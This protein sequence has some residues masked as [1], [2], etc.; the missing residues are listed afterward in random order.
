MIKWFCD[1]C[2][3]EIT[4]TPTS[5]KAYHCLKSRDDAD[6]GWGATD[7]IVAVMCHTK[8]ADILQTEIRTALDTAK[9]VVKNNA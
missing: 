9:R 3:L 5:V 6:A 7:T 4:S 2:S 1:I 8:C